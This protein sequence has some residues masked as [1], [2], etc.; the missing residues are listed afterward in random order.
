MRLGRLLVQLHTVALISSMAFEPLA[1]A[2]KA[3]TGQNGKIATPPHRTA[4]DSLRQA[5][6]LSN[7]VQIQWRTS[8]N[9]IDTVSVLDNFNRA[10]LGADWAVDSRYWEI[11][12][13]ELVLTP[14]ANSEWRYLAVFKKIANDEETKI[15]SVSYRWGKGAD[16]VGIGEG[17]HALMLSRAESDA[18]GYWCWRRTNQKSVWLY[19]I[20]NGNWEYS[21][22]A[23]KEYDRAP[24]RLTIPR[25]GDVVEAVI[26]NESDGVYFDYHINGQYDATVADATKEFGHHFP[27][28]AGVF[29]H[30]QSLNNAV[31]DFRVTWT[32]NDD[33]AP[34]RVNDLNA[35]EVTSNSVT[36]EW[37][38]TGDN[39]YS[40]RADSYELR[41][42]TS[43]ISA[44]NFLSATHIRDLP[45]P[46][47]PGQKQQMTVEGLEPFTVYYFA[48]RVLDEVGN[49]S[50]ISNVL[51]TRTQST[52]VPTGLQ[53]VEGCGQS[54]EV[55]KPLPLK[56]VAKVVDQFGIGVPNR[57]V[58]F[59]IISGGGNVQGTTSLA[60]PS[61][62]QGRAAAVWTLG[63][64]PG[65]NK[66]EIRSAGLTGSPI[67][68]NATAVTGSAAHLKVISNHRRLYP[69]NTVSDPLAVRLTDAAGNPIGG[70]ALKFSVIV[71]AGY[72]IEGQLPARKI[73]QTRADSNGTARVTLNTGAVWGDT[74]K[75]SVVLEAANEIALQPPL[76]VIAAPPDSMRVAG[77]NQQSALLNTTLPEPLRVQVF[78]A[79]G[80]PAANQAVTFSVIAGGGKLGNGA[81]QIEIA[82][83]DQ[84]FAQTTLK[85]GPQPIQ[86]QVR[87][88][89]QFKGKA[90]RRSPLIFTAL[91]MNGSISPGLSALMVSPQTGLLADSASAAMVTI[92]IYDEHHN[93][94]P[95]KNVRIG[96]TGE[97]VFIQQPSAPTDLNGQAFA[98]VRSAK[99]GFKT[100][101]AYVL[102]ENL[103]LLDS[104]RVRFNEI[105][106]AHMRLL[107]G[108]SQTAP[109]GTILP[110]PLAVEL[111]DRFGNPPRPTTV[112]FTVLS[113]GGTIIGYRNLT[114][115]SKGQARGVW[116]LG[117]TGGKQE[118]EARV[119]TIGGSPVVF[120]AHAT[121]G[122][123]VDDQ[124]H[125]ALPTAFALLQNS[126]NP[127]NPE[128]DIHF[129]LA[130][131][132]EVEM[133]LYDLNGRLITRLLSGQKPA[134]RH[135]L[136]WQ[137][138]NQ[139]GQPLES[140]VYVY[141][142]RA[143]YGRNHQEFLATRKLILL[144]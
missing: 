102:P 129:D 121:G 9:G 25:A 58:R 110:Q 79:T 41:Y 5:L 43:P 74:T 82:T 35:R 138:R 39:E 44:Q 132:A 139:H 126:P 100:I 136:R 78:D 85:L 12:N 98:K 16:A 140:G 96:V 24:A 55:G 40:G 89:S 53:L 72:L 80:A 130:E 94:V 114:T 144:K 73:Y 4:V 103:V 47:D 8:S 91:A 133:D 59:V 67:S 20:K 84:G 69:V 83:N 109:A 3:A 142:M 62:G 97:S 86:H 31:D 92:E 18:D 113:G 64:T 90:L 143:R 77:G 131:A 61:D 36:L 106:A 54:G 34:A 27:W 19:A 49:A 101:S 95:G 115:D 135:R 137:G 48:M 11:R 107:S 123:G 46:G 76:F 30:G 45:D 125:A 13:G 38:A 75:V 2:A 112:T 6:G 66:I 116:Q 60:V 71:G 118:L 26:K 111:L 127:F 50:G 128:T 51:Q 29:I 1:S 81:A 119:N 68:C 63:N 104:V 57:N 70:G 56:I 10:N 88:E 32:H 22:G 87:V 117:V 134:G 108:D 93:P 23:S 21:T 120:T 37:T 141:R 33:V 17:A 28:Y 124:P 52:G 15:Y 14:A 42:S 7:N 99:A 105:A 65:L 122:T